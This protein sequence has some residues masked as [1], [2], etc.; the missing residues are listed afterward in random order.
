MDE[1]SQVSVENRS[2]SNI[3]RTKCHYRWGLYATPNIVTKEDKDKLNAIMLNF[4]IVQK[5]MIVQTTA[6]Y[7]QFAKSFPIFHKLFCENIIAAIR[8]S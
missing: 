3:M 2:I 1:A 5:D 6:S 7:N 8:K 4:H